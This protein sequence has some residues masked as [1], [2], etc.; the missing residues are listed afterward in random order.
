MITEDKA[1]LS[2]STLKIIAIITM[3]IDH[4][5]A[6]VL[7]NMLHYSNGTLVQ[8]EIFTLYVISR[9]IGR[10]SF[11]IF[12]FLLV[13]GFV[14]TKNVKEY[15]MRLMIFA[16][17]SEIPFDLALSGKR[18]NP[19]GQNVFFTLWIGLLVLI[20]LKKC[21]TFDKKWKIY[22]GR[23]L[24]LMLGSFASLLLSTDYQIHGIISI[25]VIYLFRYNKTY[26]A[27]AGACTFLWEPTAVLGFIPIYF[28]NGK[29][30]LNMK[31]IFYG[32]YPVHLLILYAI[33]NKYF[34]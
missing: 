32:F 3:L 13:E 31:Y 18:F 1:L 2:G 6:F 20:G 29:R 7:V 16:F 17:I 28:Y 25:A 4:I 12:C 14:H 11:P 34:R 21:E 10:I 5:G 8:D 27:L 33:V 26:Q 9:N 23:L 19:F 30:G 22:G 24:A 15:A